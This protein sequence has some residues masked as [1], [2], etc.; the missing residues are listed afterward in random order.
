MAGGF[1]VLRAKT[2]KVEGRKAWV[3]G[4]I[5]TLVGEGEK[6]VKLVEA[7]AL[8]I[9]PRQAAVSETYISV[10]GIETD[11][12][13]EHGNS[14]PCLIDSH[15]FSTRRRGFNTLGLTRRLNKTSDYNRPN[16]TAF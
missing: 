1:I 7:T 4:H 2:I 10:K 14:I 8:F 3:E 12:T 15:K 5:E 6:P 9:E 13:I 11:Y 16:R